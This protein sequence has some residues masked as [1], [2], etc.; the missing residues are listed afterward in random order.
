MITVSCACGSQWLGLSGA[1][2]RSAA[3]LQATLAARQQWKDSSEQAM[4]KL[5]LIATKQLCS[6]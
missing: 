2:D 3:R 6:T 5:L 1:A 4:A